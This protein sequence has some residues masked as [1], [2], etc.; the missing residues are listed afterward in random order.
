MR[1]H[2]S[3]QQ[4]NRVHQDKANP[5]RHKAASP[6][7]QD[8]GNH[9]HHKA[10][11]HVHQGKANHVRQQLQAKGN[12]VRKETASVRLHQQKLVRTSHPKQLNRRQVQANVLQDVQEAE[13]AMASKTATVKGSSSNR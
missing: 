12:P 8:K 5:V 10:A 2:D 7:H 3:V 9:V 11:S 13:T 1:L 6:V 4:H